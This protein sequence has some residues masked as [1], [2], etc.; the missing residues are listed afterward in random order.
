MK[1]QTRN[2]QHMRDHR[3]SL[4]PLAG[5]RRRRRLPL[6]PALLVIAAVLSYFVAR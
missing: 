6:V 4:L 3:R 2:I 5:A 1:T